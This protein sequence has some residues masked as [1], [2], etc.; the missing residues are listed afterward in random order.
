MVKLSTSTPI[1]SKKISAEPKTR[2]EGALKETL[3]L[4]YRSTFCLL[5]HLIQI[6]AGCHAGLIFSVF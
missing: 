5:D 1:D 6:I 3:H 4:V 2:R